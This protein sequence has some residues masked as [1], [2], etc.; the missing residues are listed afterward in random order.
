M[1]LMETVSKRSSGPTELLW[2]RKVRPFAC[3]ISIDP[4][5]INL[6]IYKITAHCSW[7]QA[8]TFPLRVTLREQRILNS[9]GGQ[10]QM[11][12]ERY[13]EAILLEFPRTWG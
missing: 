10:I 8:C 5:D 13:A 2:A 11:V 12:S 7:L 1:S 3:F 4:S 6:S 9:R